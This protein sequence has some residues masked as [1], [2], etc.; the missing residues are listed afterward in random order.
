M[1]TH[2][3]LEFLWSEIVHLSKSQQSFVRAEKILKLRFLTYDP[4]HTHACTDRDSMLDALKAEIKH[5]LHLL[6]NLILAFFLKT[7]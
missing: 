1:Y 4:L 6:L 5:S 2:K 7:F 3:Y